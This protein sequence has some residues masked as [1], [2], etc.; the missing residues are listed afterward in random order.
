[1][2]II[3]LQR[4]IESIE[5]RVLKTNIQETKEK[6]KKVVQEVLSFFYGVGFDWETIPKNFKEKIRKLDRFAYGPEKPVKHPMGN[7][8]TGKANKGSKT[9]HLGCEKSG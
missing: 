1:M 9:D 2:D 8:K 7:R 6:A 4:K 3:G 5:N